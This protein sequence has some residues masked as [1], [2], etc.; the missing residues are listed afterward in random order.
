MRAGAL[1][2]LTKPVRAED[3]LAAV[4]LALEQ[5]AVTREDSAEIE[6]IKGR[7]GTLTPRERGPSPCHC[8]RRLNK[9]I[10]WHLGITQRTVKLHRRQVMDKL[11][12]RS[13][14]DLVRVTQRA[15]IAPDHP[16]PQARL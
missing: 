1:N 3:L 13:V 4:R 15:G 6:A 2:V 7:L 12:V 8:R 16:G 14:A 5:D 11:A 9:Q 10:A